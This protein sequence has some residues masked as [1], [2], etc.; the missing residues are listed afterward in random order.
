[1]FDQLLSA[2]VG[3]VVELLLQLRQLTCQRRGVH[4]A[5]LCATAALVW[6]QRVLHLRQL[7]T[8]CCTVTVYA[9]LRKI[10]QVS[11]LL[12]FDILLGCNTPTITDR[13]QAA[14]LLAVFLCLWYPLFALC[15][16]VF[17]LCFVQL[18]TA[19][20]AMKGYLAGCKMQH[21]LPCVML[22]CIE[23]LHATQLM[24]CQLCCS[25]FKGARKVVRDPL[26]KIAWS[27]SRGIH[28]VVQRC[29]MDAV[30]W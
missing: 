13:L 5:P 15:M 19:L 29:A 9:W 20:R 21:I 12:G 11:V 28:L 25:I 18:C 7:Q 17:S 22:L 24:G 2:L 1:M 6:R 30:V 14:L 16:P 8:C 23:R 26:L 4:S 10:Y 27:L 3:V